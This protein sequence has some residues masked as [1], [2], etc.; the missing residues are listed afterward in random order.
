MKVKL[1]LRIAA[2]I[3][4]GSTLLGIA[5]CGQQQQSDN[6]PSAPA[7][8]MSAP[9]PSNG[10]IKVTAPPLPS[11]LPPDQVAKIKEQMQ[12]AQDQANAYRAQELAAAAARAA[13]H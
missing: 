2:T 12:Q 5:G 13:K 7:A 1:P 6:I 11:N 3:V 4:L 10:P 9:N 8:T